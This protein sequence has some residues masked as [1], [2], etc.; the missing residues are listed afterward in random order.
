VIEV[1]GAAEQMRERVLRARLAAIERLSARRG[2]AQ[3]R[4]AGPKGGGSPRF[5]VLVL[6]YGPAKEQIVSARAVAAPPPA[7]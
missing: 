3:R 6:R 2:R 1:E 4:L 7:R 5:G